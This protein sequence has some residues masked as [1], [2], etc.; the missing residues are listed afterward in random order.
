MPAERA[1]AEQLQ[2]E[3]AVVAAYGALPVARR[4][5][6]ALAPVG[7]APSASARIDRLEAAGAQAGG[8]PASRPRTP[9]L[10]AVLDAERPRCAPTSPRVG[11][12]ERPRVRELLAGLDQP[13]AAHESALLVLLERP[14]LPTAFPGQPSPDDPH[15]A[16]DRAA[17]RLRAAR[18]AGLRRAAAPAVGR[19][20][21]RPTRAGCCSGCGGARW[22][23]RSRTTGSCTSIR[24]SSRCAATRPTTPPRWRPSSP[25]SGSGRRGRR[26]GPRTSTRPP[27]ASPVPGPDAR[28]SRAAVALE[29]ELVALYPSAL[30]ALPDAKIAMTAATILASHSQHLLILRRETADRDGLTR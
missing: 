25:R 27:S 13:S 2:A 9:G 30:P 11:Q 22:A 1:C 15:R 23:R 24:C 8:A 18:R 4:G 3:R 14:P 26:S 28:R 21:P 20:G 6:R 16:D 17:G 29:E 19:R 12:L 10:E 5:R 7:A